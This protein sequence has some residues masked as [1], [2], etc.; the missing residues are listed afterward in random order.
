M[1]KM[2]E[3]KKNKYFCLL[4][5]IDTSS[6]ESDAS[7]FRTIIQYYLC[8]KSAIFNKVCGYSCMVNKEVYFVVDTS[9]KMAWIHQAAI[10]HFE[11]IHHACITK[12]VFFSSFLVNWTWF[13]FRFAAI[14][15]EMTRGL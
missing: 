9:C 7:P 3:K 10:L 15:A 2:Y 1:L 13:L 5:V 8:R 6:L 4:Q 11:M 14:N 12:V